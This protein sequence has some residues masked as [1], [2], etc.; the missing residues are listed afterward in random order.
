MEEESKVNS[1]EEERF[2]ETFC[3]IK[4]YFRYAKV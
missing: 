3:K 1:I 4:F 2:I